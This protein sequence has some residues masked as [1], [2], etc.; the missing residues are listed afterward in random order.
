MTLDHGGLVPS[1]FNRFLHSLPIYFHQ[2][3][4]ISKSLNSTVMN[5]TLKTWLIAFGIGIFISLLMSL[6]LLM[7]SGFTV[8]K[9]FWA[10]T[11]E[12]TTLVLM[13]TGAITLY[14]TRD[15]W[16]HRF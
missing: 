16:K 13:L 8:D 5:K 1:W 2:P 4:L 15:E 6:L 3:L 11:G 10:C 12:Y 9:K 7:S 14:V